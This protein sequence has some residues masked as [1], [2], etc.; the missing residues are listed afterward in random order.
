M[1]SHP[2]ISNAVARTVVADRIR[3]AEAFRLARSVRRAGRLRTA[4]QRAALGRPG[5]RL[6]P[7]LP[8]VHDT[9]LLRRR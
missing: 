3:E 8:A 1:L 5:G 2:T 7:Q 9:T 4:M 6:R